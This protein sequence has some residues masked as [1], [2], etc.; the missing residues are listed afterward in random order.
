MSRRLQGSLVIQVETSAGL[1]VGFL[2]VMKGP[3][4]GTLGQWPGPED[5]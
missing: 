3:S 2:V 4:L 5:P 1:S